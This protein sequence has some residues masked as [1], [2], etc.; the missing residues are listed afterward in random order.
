MRRSTLESNARW[1]KNSERDGRIL[2]RFRQ[3]ELRH[4]RNHSLMNTEPITDDEAPAPRRGV[5][6]PDNPRVVA[7][8]DALD[9]LTEADFRA[10]AK[11]KPSTAEAWRKRGHGPAYILL[12]NRVLYP[13]EAL[14]KYLKEL[15]RERRIDPRSLL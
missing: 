6:L 15:Q 8:A 2:Y 1:K 9:C 3:A 7:L 4:E 11:I 13:K 10:L 5:D 14:R 12:G